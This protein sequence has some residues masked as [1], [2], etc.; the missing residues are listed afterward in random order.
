MN[1]VIVLFDGYST[2]LENGAMKANCSCTLIKGTKNIIVDTMT[3]WDRD[4]IVEGIIRYYFNNVFNLCTECLNKD[5][6]PALTLHNITP[7]KIDY[8]VC[9]HGHADHTGNNNLFTNAEHI[10][11]NCVHRGEM[12]FE[13]DLKNGE[14]LYIY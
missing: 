8:V 5:I 10:V 14:D 9:T 2:K 3:A 13:K 11:G 7:D 6:I 4:R 12:F 1:E